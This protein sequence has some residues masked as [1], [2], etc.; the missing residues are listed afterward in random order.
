MN[1]VCELLD[2]DTRFFAVRIARVVGDSL[3]ETTAQQVLSWCAS[4]QIDCLYF[5][6]AANSQESIATV[7]RH[8][9]GL[10]DVRL[11]YRRRLE[12][13]LADHVPV[14]PA[15]VRVRPSRRDE[16]PALEA[17]TEGSF[18]D[19]RF[20][21]DHRFSRSKVD[22]MYRLWVQ[23]SIAGQADVV[24]VLENEGRV[25]GFITCHLLDKRTGQCRLGGLEAN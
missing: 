25:S 12:P 17:I 7:E 22:E 5:L 11:T 23:Q 10:K 4:E 9:F 19:S 8:G 18:T 21:Y 24:L 14:L 3:D 16:A 6:A 1:T 20:Y 13:S 2:W 15:G